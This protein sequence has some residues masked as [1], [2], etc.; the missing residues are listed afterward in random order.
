MTGAGCLASRD[1]QS[2]RPDIDS[3]QRVHNLLESD[4]NRQEETVG[5]QRSSRKSSCEEQRRRRSSGNRWIALL[6]LLL[7]TSI[8]VA[9]GSATAEPPEPADSGLPTPGDITR[10]IE[11]GDGIVVPAPSTNLAAAESLPR[12]DLNRQE[13]SELLASVFPAHL[14]APA[15]AF[16]E[17]E[18]EKF[19]APNV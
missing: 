3:G 5:E 18:V 7:L 8:A 10:E 15:G 16:D 9:T 11:S 12:A 6:F 19:L 2:S 17:L 1:A 14:Q 4:R 13:A